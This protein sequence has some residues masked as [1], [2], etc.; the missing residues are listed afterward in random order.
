MKKPLKNTFNYFIFSLMLLIVFSCNN[1]KYLVPG[2]YLYNGAELKINSKGKVENKSKLN[3][4]LQNLIYPEPNSKFLGARTKLWFYNITEEPE[5]S[6]GFK[7]WKKYK[8]GEPPVLMKHTDPERVRKLMKNHLINSGYFNAEAEYKVIPKEKE[9]SI[10]YSVSIDTAY[11]INEIHFPEAGDYLSNSIANTKEATLLKAGENYSLSTLEQERQRISKALKSEGFYFFEAQFLKF[12]VDST[13][14]NR[15]VNIYLEVK[16]N[17]NEKFLQTYRIGKIYV[18]PNYSLDQDSILSSTDTLYSNGCYYLLQDSGKFRPEIITDAVFLQ[19]GK[20]YNQKAHQ[21][22]LQRLIGLGAF[23]FVNIEY[24][25]D[26]D[27]SG[28]LTSHIY[29]TPFI[30]KSLRLELSVTTK[31]NGFTGPGFNT[32]FRNRNALRGSE[33]FIVNVTTGYETQISGNQSGLNSFELG[34]STELVV[35]RFITPFE[36]RHVS[37]RYIP[38][39]SFK[40]GFRILKRVKYFLTNSYDASFG[41]K[42]RET[43]TKLHELYPV[44][45]NFVNLANAEPIFDSLL[46]ANPLLRRSFE[47]QFILGT[48]YTYTFNS[49]L[50]ESRKNDFFFQGTAD[51]AGNL[52]GLLGNKKQN[53]EQGFETD[54]NFSFAGVPFSQYLKFET[55]FKHYFNISD[56]SQIASRFSAGVGIPTGNSHTLPYIKQFFAGGSNSIRAFHTRSLGPGTYRPKDEGLRSIY[57]DQ[58]GDIKLELNTEY[59]F[60]IFEMIKGAIFLDIG[61]IWLANEDPNRPGGKFEAKN[62]MNELAVG[63]GFG[64]RIDPGFF[65][66][67]FDFGFP[68]RKPYL[69]EGKR[70]VSSQMD[71]ASSEWR[72]ENVIL[73]I[74]IGYPF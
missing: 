11:K 16:G 68:L 4:E 41:Y 61:N 69:P 24:V 66:L 6:K 10:L 35:P 67:R 38:K 33:L 65:V 40:L 22:T 25:P 27:T 59:R 14:G 2:Q 21:Y 49:K 8:L 71:F 5:K 1:E 17:I 18:Y 55:I 37:S 36:I 29:L 7:Y 48:V 44:S 72:K 34:L 15:S 32:S 28:I 43:A 45:F 31:S 58:A 20:L 30:K 23:Q 13:I 9:A 42:W 70:W 47:E 3:R 54:T 19:S 12:K 50:K 74:A 73:N 46:T 26:A 51:V 39:T 56:R 62:F 64:L 52:I 53:P 57:L 60:T 63:S